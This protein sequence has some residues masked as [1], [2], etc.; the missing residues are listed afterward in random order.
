MN[1]IKVPP[2]ESMSAS[3]RKLRDFYHKKP[4]APFVFREFGFYSLD[5]WI[6]EG[7]LKKYSDVKGDYNEYLK[8][9]FGFDEPAHM[10]IWHL[11]WC[12]AE[13][14]PKFD[15]ILIEDRGD[16]EVVQDFAGRHVLFFKNRRSGFMPEYLTSPVTDVKSWEENVAWRLSAETQERFKDIDR[17]IS[18][19]VQA[20][21]E[22]KIISQR[23]VGGYMYL[24]SLIGPEAL[25]YAFYDMPELIHACMENWL[26][27]ADSVTEYIQ[28]H[29][30]YDEVFL[31]E[32]ICYNSGPLISLDMIK[33][34]LFPYYQQLITNIKVR[35]LDKERDLHVQI[36]TD[37]FC[38]PVIDLYRE[39]VGADY[40]SP[41]EAASKSDILESSKKW[42][43]LLMMGGIDK[44]ILA[45]TR[46]E[47]DRYLDNILPELHK[48]GGFIPTC[49]HGVPEEV[50]FENYMHFRKRLA[51]FA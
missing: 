23:M 15:E 43:D 9:I 49:D 30:S 33:K 37:G 38:W 6:E 40:F 27:L 5:R 36:D 50:S 35:Q 25:C 11:G 1:S 29:V 47:I 44:R 7:Y 20:Q 22:G 17:N 21:K 10:D 26:K 31:A 19:Y 51:E 18:R 34:F 42:P 24:R 16:T 13:F 3:V 41:F 46:K 2:R 4:S 32:D 39:A 12:E 14:Y 8:E 28:R 48:R 45:S